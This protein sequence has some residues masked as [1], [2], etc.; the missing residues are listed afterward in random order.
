MIKVG[1][2]L[3]A[4]TFFTPTADG[5]KAEVTTDAVFAGKTVVLVAVPGAFTPTCSKTHVPGFID[6]Y[7]AIRAKGVDAIAVTAVND[8]YVMGAWQS[9]LGAG[10]K[11]TFLADGSALFAKAIGL[12]LDLTGGGLGVRS[13]RYAAIVKDG[14]V[15]ELQVEENAGLAT[16]SAAPSILD[17]L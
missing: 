16:C 2:K 14:V 9:T 4:F 5:G 6:K 13:A 15:T 11:I 17:K 10:D 8:V 12:D 1:D 3:P 7:E